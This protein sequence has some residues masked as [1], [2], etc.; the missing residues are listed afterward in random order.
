MWDMV[1]PIS[2]VSASDILAEILE[3]DRIEGEPDLFTAIQKADEYQTRFGLYVRPE[4]LLD[5]MLELKTN[6]RQ[7]QV[8]GK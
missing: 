6:L 7:N 1:S 4:F 3:H 8:I 5:K 2:T